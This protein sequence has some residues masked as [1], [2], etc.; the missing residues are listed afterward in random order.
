M[1]VAAAANINVTA[2]FFDGRTYR[3]LIDFEPCSKVIEDGA[4]GQNT[5]D[6]LLGFYR[7][8]CRVS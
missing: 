7:N 4:I 2:I 3:L 6:F 1:L 8:F 5:Y